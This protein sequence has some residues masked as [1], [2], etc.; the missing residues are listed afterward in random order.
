MYSIS[1]RNVTDFLE[2]VNIKVTL[3]PKSLSLI[4]CNIHCN[5]N[6]K[7]NILLVCDTLLI[8]KTRTNKRFL[9]IFLQRSVEIYYAKRYNSMVS[10]HYYL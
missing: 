2:A 1:V 6:R 5:V 7:Q 10:F 3:F 9:L 8:Q 4:Q